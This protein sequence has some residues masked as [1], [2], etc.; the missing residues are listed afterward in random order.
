V[1]ERDKYLTEAMG[2]CWH[3]QHIKNDKHIWCVC[4]EEFTRFSDLREHIAYRVESFSTWEG[5]GKLKD[6]MCNLPDSE[7]FF[8][9][10][11]DELTQRADDVTET[12]RRLQ[13]DHFADVVY[14]FLKERDK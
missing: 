4:G 6:F 5:F 9:S 12:F 10:Y 14:E 7:R 8:D 3:E 2:E 11:I 1:S 13:P